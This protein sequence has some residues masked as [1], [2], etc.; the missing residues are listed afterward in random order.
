MENI[1]NI[2]NITMDT[3][4]DAAAVKITPRTTFGELLT[5]LGL[6]AGQKRIGRTPK[7]AAL[8]AESG[9]AVVQMCGISV[10]RNG[11]ALYENGFGRYSVLWLPY[12]TRFTYCFNKLRDAEKDYLR[13]I[14]DL[15]EDG[16]KKWKWMPVIALFG[17]E[18]ITQKLNRGFGNADTKNNESSEDD[19]VEIEPE[20]IDWEGLNFVWDDET[21]GV[22]PLNA[23]IRRE[24][25]ENM[26]AAMTDKQREVFILYHKYGWTQQQIAYIMKVSQ[27]AVNKLLS[28]ANLKVQKYF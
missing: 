20:D 10:F 15:P 27:Q 7:R 23:V 13:E 8:L 18:R 4:A 22:D 14:A 19:E 1:K 9:E 11:Y 12:C 21:L 28:K 25:R 3:V 5:I 17:E 6:E 24:T 16:F 2:K 26:L